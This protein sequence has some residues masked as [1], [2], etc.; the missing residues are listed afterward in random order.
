MPE[1]N[2]HLILAYLDLQEHAV[3]TNV[4]RYF[5]RICDSDAAW[6]NRLRLDEFEKKLPSPNET[7]SLK[8]WYQK[9]R[10]ITL[11]PYNCLVRPRPYGRLLFRALPELA[12][13]Q[14]LNPPP[15]VLD[16]V[17]KRPQLL[18]R[19]RLK[20]Y[21]ARQLLHLNKSIQMILVLAIVASFCALLSLH[22][23]DLFSAIPI[24]AA[25]PIPHRAVHPAERESPSLF[26]KM[27]NYIF[28]LFVHVLAFFSQRSARL[29]ESP[30]TFDRTACLWYTFGRLVMA[31]R[32]SVQVATGLYALIVL[33]ET[34]RWI[35]RLAT[36]AVT[37]HQFAKRWRPQFSFV[38]LFLTSVSAFGACYV[39]GVFLDPVQIVVKAIGPL[40]RAIF[41][42]NIELDGSLWS[43]DLLSVAV[44]GT[45]YFQPSLDLSEA[46]RK[47]SSQSTGC[48]LVFS[49]TLYSLILV[50]LCLTQGI[51][52]MLVT[53][54]MGEAFVTF[55]DIVHIMVLRNSSIDLERF[56]S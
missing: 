12:V 42:S 34:L 5:N 39:V 23:T 49:S 28:V 32:C 52:P 4:N 43:Q 19:L 17:R 13:Y 7:Q 11:A 45:I 56:S 24:S 27:E 1:D 25:I 40:L 55:A 44:I 50:G 51:L 20:Q 6:A 47:R 10:R 41:L 37:F 53:A 2:V 38:K 33:A 31:L 9:K 3:L 22:T 16:L 18:R 21:V 35:S 15:V 36:I 54:L 8:K 14:L 26:L 29:R 46:V 48:L 30:P